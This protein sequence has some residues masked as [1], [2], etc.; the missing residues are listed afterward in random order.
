M[1]NIRLFMYLRHQD[2]THIDVFKELDQHPNL[3]AV[4]YPM[5]ALFIPQDFT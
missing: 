4:Y 3:N 5:V 1:Q 2:I